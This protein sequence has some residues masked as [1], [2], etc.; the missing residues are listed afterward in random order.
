M[1]RKK[2]EVRGPWSAMRAANL[3]PDST[4]YYDQDG[5]TITV[6]SKAGDYYGE[7]VD[8]WL[9]VFRSQRTKKPVG[10]EIAGVTALML[11]SRRKKEYPRWEADQ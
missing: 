3:K 1:V 2:R 7:H 8:K 11:A 6:I 9:T 4:P 10:F 5:D